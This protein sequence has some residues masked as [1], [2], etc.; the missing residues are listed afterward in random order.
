V[1]AV[2]GLPF[3]IRNPHGE[4]I[5][6]AFHPTGSHGGDASV[7]PPDL[8]VIG[9][10]VT[11]NKD[12]PWLIALSEALADAGIPSLRITFAGNGESEGRYED[13]TPSKEAGDLGSVIDALAGWGVARICYAGHSMGGAVGVLRASADP[14]IRLLVSLA[15]MVHVHAFMQRHFGHLEPGRDLMLDKPGCPWNTTLAE[16]AA[17]IGSLTE[18]A[19]RIEV[20][21]LLVHGDADELVPL[22]DSEDARA[23]AGGCPDLVVLPGVDHRFTG[24]VPAM[25]AAVVQ[26]LEQQLHGR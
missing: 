16:D 23:A 7:A 5:D 18:Q 26:W 15:G 19:S 10:G 9:H 21:W 13:A 14:R 25:T 24:A 6:V 22:A 2:T 4:R 17:R 12:R 8:V 1:T 3:A 20:P 11:S